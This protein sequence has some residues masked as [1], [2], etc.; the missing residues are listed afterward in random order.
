MRLRMWATAGPTGIAFDGSHL[1]VT[2]TIGNSVTALQ[3]G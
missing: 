1:W 2:D 3:G